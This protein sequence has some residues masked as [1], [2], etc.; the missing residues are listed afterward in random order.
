L[1]WQADEPYPAEQLAR[2][3]ATRIGRGGVPGQPRP[4]G[5][6][7][8]VVEFAGRALDALA[9]DAK[10]AAKITASR[11]DVSYVF[12]EQIPNV[13][14]WRVQFDVAAAGTDPVELRLFLGESGL[15]L[16]ETWLYQLEPRP[17]N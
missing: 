17:I 3:V 12:V 1:H 5:V 10:P 4:K 6:T 11:G 13:K 16:T 2:V 8:F 14:R 15:T 9:R 7:K